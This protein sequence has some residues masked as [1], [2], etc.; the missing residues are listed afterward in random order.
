M[1]SLPVGHDCVEV[2]T[3]YADVVR[4]T[5]RVSSDVADAVRQREIKSM[6]RSKRQTKMS[7]ENLSFL[8]AN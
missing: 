6:I 5:H 4:G 2:K 7:G 3:S 1:A 8:S